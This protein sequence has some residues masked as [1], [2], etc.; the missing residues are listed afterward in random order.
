VVTS[1]SRK[2][3]YKGEEKPGAKGAERPL[4][5]VPAPEPEPVP[6]A[7]PAADEGGLELDRDLNFLVPPMDLL[8]A[9]G[10]IP[11]SPLKTIDLG[12][13]LEAHW[14]KFILSHPD[15][16]QF[17]KFVRAAVR[18]AVREWEASAAVAREEMARVGVPVQPEVGPLLQALREE[19]RMIR[20]EESEE[21]KAVREG[22]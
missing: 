5:A 21:R 20:A 8:Y 22:F 10:S 1:K 4:Q 19:Y 6:V 2:N 3:R 18:V 9:E 15:L 12:P 14:K 7:G 11:H 16:K 17:S 13:A